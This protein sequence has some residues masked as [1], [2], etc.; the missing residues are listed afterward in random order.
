MAFRPTIQFIKL[1]QAKLEQVVSDIQWKVLEAF[2]RLAS[3]VPPVEG[4]FLKGVALKTG[5][6]TTVMHKLD[7]PAKGWIV[8]GAKVSEGVAVAFSVV[9]LSANN[10]F[11]K[12]QLLM[13]SLGADVTVDLWVY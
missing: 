11:P 8:T 4:V 7:R 13:K 10:E 5:Q 1:G 9:E 12:A 3:N 2:Q 6:P